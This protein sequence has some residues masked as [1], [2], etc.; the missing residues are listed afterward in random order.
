MYI[1]T[2][3]WAKKAADEAKKW[4]DV[5]VGASTAESKYSSIPDTP[6]PTADNAYFH[7][8]LNNTIIGTKWPE[9]PATGKVPLVADASS[10]ILSEPLDVSRFGII[11]A[12][13]Q[14][15]IG[16]AGLTVVIVR[17][18]LIGH[19]PSWVPVM[20]RYETHAKEGSMYNTPP[21]WAI[22]I[23]GLVFQW[24]KAEGGLAVM[25]KRNK[26]KAALLYDCLDKSPVFKPM[27]RPPYRSLM[28]ITFTTGSADSDKR[29]Q[30][31]AKKAGLINLGGHRLVCG[32]RA[33]LYN[34]MPIAGV[35]KL[36]DFIKNYT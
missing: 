27:I 35:E 11:Y 26:E 8:C 18:D 16:P 12:G 25:A 22:Y 29:F 28:N 3:I 20:L 13:A 17:E 24:I 14:K 10:C 7:I 5:R 21:C 9:L 1:D 34:A 23:A 19:A 36:C 6:L 33:S 15:N 2:G 4:V 31:E 30:A 32:L